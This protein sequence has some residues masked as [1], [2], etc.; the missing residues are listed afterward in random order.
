MC[1]YPW[2]VICLII[3]R[4]A[5]GTT[6][7]CQYGIRIYITVQVRITRCVSK[8]VTYANETLEN[9]ERGAPSDLFVS[10]YGYVH[11]YARYTDTE[12]RYP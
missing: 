2:C 6:W 11:I 5:F 8:L 1:P 9:G 3:A 10:V 7:S 4:M 12:P